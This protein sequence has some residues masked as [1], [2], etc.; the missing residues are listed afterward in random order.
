VRV[1]SKDRR[2]FHV[3]VGSEDMGAQKIADNVDVVIKRIEAKLE[4]GKNSLHSI[5]VKTTM[6]PAE[7]VV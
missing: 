5:F 3:V 1:R 7:R 6:G 4:Q 2:T